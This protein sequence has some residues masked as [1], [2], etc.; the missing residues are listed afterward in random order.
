MNSPEMAR[1]LKRITRLS[2]LDDEVLA[3]LARVVTAEKHDPGFVICQQGEPGDKFYAIEFG[4]VLV[5]HVIGDEEITVAHL[6]EGDV[7]GERAL[8]ESI[9]PRTARI[10]ANTPVE[11]LALHRKDYRQLVQEHPSLERILVGPEVVPLLGQVRLFSRL[12]REELTALSEYTGV[13]FYPPGRRVVEQG[14]IGTTMFVVI[15]G[16]LVAYRLDERGQ[17]RPVKALR[18]G[19]VFGQTSLLIGEPRDATVMTRTYAELCYLNRPS[20]DAFSAAYPNVQNKLQ[21]RPDVERKRTARPFP[22]QDKDEFIEI[23]DSKHWMAFLTAVA[24][25]VLWLG[26]FGIVLAV[27]DSFWLGSVRQAMGLTWLPVALTMLWVLAA[28]AVFAWHWVDWRNDYHIVTTQRVIHIENVLWRSTYRDEVPIR[29]V[30]NVSVERDLWGGLLGYGHVCITTA[31]AAG[32]MVSLEYVYEPEAFEQTIFEQL[33]RAQYRAAVAERAELRRAIRQTIGLSVL[34]EEVKEEPP[35]EKPERLSWTALL[36]QNPL[37]RRLHKT[38]TESGLATFLRRPHLPKQEI[39]LDDRVVWRKHWG[40]LLKVTYRPLLT[41]LLFFGLTLVATAGWL[42]WFTLLGISPSLFRGALLALILSLIAALGWLAWEVEDWR[43]DLYIVTNTHIIDIERITPI[44]LKER[45]RQASLDNIQNT[46]ASTEGFWAGRLKWGDVIIETAG[47][48]TFEFKQVRNPNKVQAEIDKRRE[49][50]R[51]R[52]RR[53]QVDR[54]RADLAKWFSVYHDV[55]R[56]EEARTRWQKEP[57]PQI[58]LEGPE[59][60]NES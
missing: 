23:M 50:H 17:T 39:R 51:A 20:F 44:L 12:S 36:T 15:A 35:P 59:E 7:F 29:Q 54:Q 52:Q 21:V 47:E 27:V 40:I 46:R 13:L 3:D 48:G 4:D 49:A 45:K 60:Q 14:D 8:A 56:A 16:D 41:C 34:E 57:P 1:R 32:G 53:E 38:A 42:E 2:M 58:W 10:T 11:L 37:T 19:D 33:A 26:L 24:R 43:N 22:G 28:V 55:M 30:Q 9:L 31:G 18:K 5:Q 25:P 6:F